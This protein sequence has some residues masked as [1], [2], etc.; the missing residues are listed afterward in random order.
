MIR[1]KY[2]QLNYIFDW[3]ASVVLIPED[4]AERDVPENRA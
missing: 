3:V 4:W 1:Y 2:T